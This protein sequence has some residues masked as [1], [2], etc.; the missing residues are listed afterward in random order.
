VIVS[1]N[2]PAFGSAAN[3]L[4]KEAQKAGI[5]VSGWYKLDYLTSTGEQEVINSLIQNYNDGGYYY[6]SVST[7][8]GQ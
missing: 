1:T 8:V 3:A 5:C 2:D 6:L 7:C 4:L